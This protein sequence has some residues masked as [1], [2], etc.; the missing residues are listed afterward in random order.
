[1]LWKLT[2]EGLGK[3]SIRR[4]NATLRR[5]ERLPRKIWSKLSNEELYGLVNRL[6]AEI[7][8]K[9]R[10]AEIKKE[11]N[12]S[13]A[14]FSA[15]D[16]EEF[17]DFVKLSSQK[18]K[19]AN[20]KLQ[21]LRNYYFKFFLEQ[22]TYITRQTQ[23]SKELN[24]YHWILSE[25]KL[26]IRTV[27]AVVQ[28]INQFHA[29]LE[30]KYEDVEYHKFSK[31]KIPLTL[32]KQMM[33]KRET[34]AY[35]SPD[36]YRVICDHIPHH[37]V[38][39]VFLA[40][41]YGLRLSETLSFTV[42]KIY[43][44]HIEV[45]DQQCTKVGLRTDP[46]DNESRDVEHNFNSAEELYKLVV[47]IKEVH[48]DYLSRKFS[49]TTKLLAEKGLIKRHVDFHSLRHSFCTNLTNKAL[50]ENLELN[51]VRLQMGHEDLR[52]MQRYLK[53]TKHREKINVF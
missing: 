8:T 42:Q 5:Q 20:T 32:A 52:T 10:I 16:F 31:K 7:E 21:L 9:T 23:K 29:F 39:F 24:F 50:K 27:Q 38:P 48:K 6:N 4:Y 30:D 51:E 1:M 11:I 28:I 53:A 12:Y 44:S 15:S 3:T 36:E 49:K 2:T 41:N 34:R 43:R 13:H 46:K 25:K 47:N 22:N 35:I 45:N 18:T 37:L 40:Y 17:S 19:W 14:Y 26:N 33:R